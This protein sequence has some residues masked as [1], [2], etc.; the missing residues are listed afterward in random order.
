MILHTPEQKGKHEVFLVTACFSFTI[1][2]V[3]LIRTSKGKLTRVVNA[4]NPIYS[5]HD[6]GRKTG[7]DGKGNLQEVTGW[8]Y[9]VMCEVCSK[10]L[11]S[12][13]WMTWWIRTWTVHGR[14]WHVGNTLMPQYYQKKL[15]RCG[16]SMHRMSLIV[17]SLFIFYHFFFFARLPNFLCV[18]N[19]KFEYLWS[20]YFSDLE[21][22][23][24]FL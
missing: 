24:A 16:L 8:R 7:G 20:S 13:R 9:V 22:T 1:T 3:K 18:S 12:P 2:N 5:D 19:I 4:F 23:N 11:L 15:F 14:Y 21:F 6:K 17:L 10:T